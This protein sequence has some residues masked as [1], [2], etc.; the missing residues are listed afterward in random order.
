MPNLLRR[1]PIRN[2]M[3]KRT[4]KALQGSIRK[5]EKIVEGTG[6][7]RGSDNC[8]LCKEFT[9]PVLCRGC[10]VQTDMQ[11]GGCI[12]TP[13]D[14]WMQSGGHPMGSK[15]NTEEKFMAA[16]LELAYLK[17]LLPRQQ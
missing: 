8:P 5:W 13:Y 9:Y 3:D 15:A 11:R 16:C 14:A 17:S 2:D 7:D 12:G 10:P 6:V 4:L 1:P